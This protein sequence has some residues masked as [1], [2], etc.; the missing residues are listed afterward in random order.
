MDCGVF[1]FKVALIVE[2]RVPLRV[3]TH[4]KYVGVN[5]RVELTAMRPICRLLE[6]VYRQR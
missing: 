3:I 2:Q 4:I 1:A 5:D 6:I